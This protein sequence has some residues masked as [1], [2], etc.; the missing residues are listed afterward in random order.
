MSNGCETI[1]MVFSREI[2]KIKKTN[3]QMVRKL[4]FLFVLSAS[5]DHLVLEI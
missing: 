2:S 1:K 4:N 3:L 5:G